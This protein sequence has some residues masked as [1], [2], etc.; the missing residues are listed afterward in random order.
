[1]C[2]HSYECGYS[3]SGTAL[4]RLDE[5]KRP[6]CQRPAL[7]AIFPAVNTA[8]EIEKAIERLPWPERESL[9]NR[10]LSR[11]FG[12]D[13]RSDAD[14]AELLGSLDEAER[15]ID[16]GRGLTGDELRQAVRKWTG[17]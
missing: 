3:F 11:R 13:A 9:E 4:A 5:P 15:E 16:E 7:R 6:P 2:P 17:R 1:M 8:A 10:L 12:L 14:R